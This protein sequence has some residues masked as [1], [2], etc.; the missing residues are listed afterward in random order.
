MVRAKPTPMAEHRTQPVEESPAQRILRAGLG[1]LWI[2]DGLLQAQPG[3][4]TMD[5][6]STIMQPA[7]TGQPAWLSGLIGWSVRLVT[8]HVAAFNAIVVVLQLAIGVLMLLPGARARRTGMWLGLVWALM[9]WLFGEGLGQLLTGSSTAL[10][11]APGSALVYAIAAG[12][13]LLPGGGAG[14]RWRGRPAVAVVA[15]ALFTLSALLQLNPLYFTALGLAAPFGQAAMMGQP[16]WLRAPIEWAVAASGS[17]PV[18]ANA[19]VIAAF[20]L[21][22]LWLLGENAGRWERALTVATIVW[23][24]IV[25]WLGQDFGMPFGGMATDPNTAAP[26]ALLV[27]TAH[28]ARR[29][30]RVAGDDPRRGA[31]MQSAAPRPA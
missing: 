16:A 23:L 26:L 7:A 22:A 8:P 14:R 4:F 12:L 9:V 18:L 29:G 21:G 20:T 31:R 17:A 3:M 13:W 19:V 2:L 27:W 25:W 28:V 30:A 24:G 1:A 10:A 5:M 15:G 11:G 6:V